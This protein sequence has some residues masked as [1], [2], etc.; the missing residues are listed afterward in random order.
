MN[1]QTLYFIDTELTGLTPEKGDRLLEIAVAKVPFC[2]PYKP[3]WTYVR[4]CHLS[5]SDRRSMIKNSHIDDTVLRMHYANGLFEEC[6]NAPF[7]ARYYEIELLEAIE[8]DDSPIVLAGSNPHFDLRA[9]MEHMPTLASRCHYS[10]L[11]VYAIVRWL[12]SL[13]VPSEYFGQSG[14]VH[15]A[16]DDMQWAINA[17]KVS[18]E[19]L[20]YFSQIHSSRLLRNYVYGKSF[21]EVINQL[22]LATPAV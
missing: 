18:A 9:L 19:L 17:L 6:A 5:T 14:S 13:G 15:R 16:L 4:Q 10:P 12:K 1:I 20:P 2:Y 22:R 21:A 8:G 11:D 3:A 7:S